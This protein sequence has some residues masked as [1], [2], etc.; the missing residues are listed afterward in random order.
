MTCDNCEGSH[1]GTYGSGRFC[2]EKCARGF[3]TKARREEINARVA[4]S[5]KGRDVGGSHFQEGF[6]PRRY[7]Y[8]CPSCGHWFREKEKQEFCAHVL[9][10][11]GVVPLEIRVP[12]TMETRSRGHQTVR[13]RIANCTFE[14][15]P[16]AEKCRRV[17]REQGDKCLH[18]GTGRMWNGQPL[19]LE[20]DH[21]DGNHGN[22]SCENLRGLC[23]NCHSQTPTYR[24][25]GGSS[26]QNAE[27][28]ELADTLVS[29]ASAP[30][31]A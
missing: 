7:K 19:V 11:K 26:G 24:N 17:F 16:I 20:I 31:G 13:D 27:V 3:A 21:I 1:D 29:K 12:F 5:L 22:N 30:E 28:V 23:P 14:E 8:Q 9:H 15:A 6:D 25:R 18:C 10:C 2:C 4:L